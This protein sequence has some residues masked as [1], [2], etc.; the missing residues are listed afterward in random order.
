MRYISIGPI[1]FL[2]QTYDIMEGLFRQKWSANRVQTFM[3]GIGPGVRRSSVQLVRRHVLDLVK[4]Q[5]IV[6]KM[7]AY[8]KPRKYALVEEEWKQDYK[9]LTFGTQTVFDPDT[10]LEDTTPWSLYSNTLPTKESALARLY[11]MHILGDSKPGTTIISAEAIQFKHKKG[12][13]Y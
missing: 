10:G 3:S 4:K 9:Y 8:E 6:A 2:R 11:E 5:G 1:R 12:A 7:G 13:S